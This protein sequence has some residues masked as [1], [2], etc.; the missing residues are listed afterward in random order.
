MILDKLQTRFVDE[1]LHQQSDRRLRQPRLLGQIGP[2]Q[3]RLALNGANDRHPVDL[4]QQ[5]LVSGDRHK[6]RGCRNEK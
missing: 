5:A 3:T 2:R 4:A 1:I 6:Y